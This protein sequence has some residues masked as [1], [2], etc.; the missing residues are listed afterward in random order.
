MCGCP[1]YGKA[2]RVFLRD[3]VDP[4]TPEVAQEKRIVGGGTGDAGEGAP[5]MLDVDRLRTDISQETSRHNRNNLT[6]TEAYRRI[7]SETP[8]LH[9]ALLAHL[10][11]RNGG[12][13]MTD[14]C[15]DLG[16]SL[17]AVDKQAL[18]SFLEH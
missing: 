3:G 18:F 15:G 8:E 14:L 5:A 9:W 10:V 12:W 11:S 2:R 7:Y 6:R 13:N 4:N 16:S 1:G 17:T